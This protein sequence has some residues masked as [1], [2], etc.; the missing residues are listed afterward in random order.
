MMKI[1]AG[2]HKGR[3]IES[4]PGKDIRPT[5][6]RTRGAVFNIL[7]HGRFYGEN[8]PIIGSRIVDIFCGTGALGLEAFSRG[9][10]HVTFVDE[11]QRAVDITRKN[12]E[13]FGEMKNASFIRSDSTRIPPA[14]K[15]CK[16]AFLDPP[17]ESGLAPKGLKSLVKGG[18]LEKGAIVVV[19]I[20]KKEELEIPE[21]FEK[22]SERIYNS[23]K[24]ILLE[25]KK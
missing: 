4:L 1:I 22:V 15:P 21:E 8:S 17:Y 18:W 14:I 20:S 10:A 5:S 19:E 24:I 9:A 25:L 11:N 16:L 23:T 13:K 2:K 12:V 3:N 7:T 6:G